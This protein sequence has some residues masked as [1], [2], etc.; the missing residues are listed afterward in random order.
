MNTD[1]ILG[2]LAAAGAGAFI[3]G[4]VAFQAAEAKLVGRHH[5]LKLSM[6]LQLLKRPQWLIHRRQVVGVA[7]RSA[8]TL[9]PLTVAAD[10]RGRPHRPAAGG[11][12]AS[13][14][15]SE[16]AGGWRWWR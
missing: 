1:L 5:G 13:V 14:S 15:T 10:A 3:D 2:I 16:C 11:P 4:A 8:L 6:M 12:I 9:A 7:C